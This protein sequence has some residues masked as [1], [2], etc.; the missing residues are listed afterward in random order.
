MK[1]SENNRPAKAGNRIWRFF[2]SIQLTVGVLL[3]LAVTS[4]IGTLIPQNESPEAYFRTYGEVLYRI[5]HAL[6]I[7]DMYHSWWFQFLLVMLSLNILVCSLDRLSSIWRVIFTKKPT[8]SIAKFKTLGRRRE[9]SAPAEA[10]SLKGTMESLVSSHFRYSR[11]EST[12]DGYCIF[13]ERNRW[14]RIGVYIVHLSVL[15][16]LM[17]GLVGSIF[18]F[19][20]FVNIPEGESAGT[21]RIRNSNRVRDLG[22]EIRCDDFNLTHYDT[23]MPKEYRS[24]LT[25]LEDGK[26]VLQK[27]IIVNDPLRYKG[28][29]IYQSSYGSL[30]P[31]T[32]SLEKSGVALSVTSKETNMTYNLEAVPGEPVN[33]PEGRGTFVLEEVLPN[34]R[35]MGQ[36]DLGETLKG[37]MRLKDQSEP[38]EILLPLRFSRF[39][40]MRRG[41]YF[42]FAVQGFEQRFYTGLQVARDPGVPLV[43]L[44]FVIMIAGCFVT[45]FMSHQRLCVAVSQKKRGAEV[46]VSGSAN[47]NPVAM[48]QLVVKMTRLLSQAAGTTDRGKTG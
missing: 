19:E 12:D 18:G 2:T 15:L 17:G 3:S 30:P 40:M 13:A 25:I 28:I 33:L 39:D 1:H 36:R 37:T 43:Y 27:D 20:G 46:M 29:N 42:V 47:K 38:V 16:L 21:I 31:D 35:F 14:T 9:F 6:D 22:F 11:T 32:A 4:I 24:S 34:Y 41:P 7:F 26:P 48:D 8:F 45:F 44:G 23:G 5:F 10:E